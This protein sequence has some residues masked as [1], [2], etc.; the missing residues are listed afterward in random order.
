MPGRRVHHGCQLDHRPA[1]AV[2]QVQVPVAVDERQLAARRAAR[3]AQ[4][5]GAHLQRVAERLALLPALRGVEEPQ[6]GAARMLQHRQRV[7]AEAHGLLVQ[8]LDA[9]A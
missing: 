7:A 1:G 4:R 9:Q 6:R 8:A 3:L 5:Q 2:Q